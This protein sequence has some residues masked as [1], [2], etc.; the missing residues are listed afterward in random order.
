MI[1]GDSSPSNSVETAGFENKLR[2]INKDT[3][4]LKQ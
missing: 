2:K 4:L 3:N 1:H